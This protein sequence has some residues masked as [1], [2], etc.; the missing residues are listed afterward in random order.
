MARIDLARRAEI[1]R[2]SVQTRSRTCAAQV[3]RCSQGAV[4]AAGRNCALRCQ[5]PRAAGQRA[6]AALENSRCVSTA[7]MAHA[8]VDGLG[9]ERIP[10]GLLRDD[11]ADD[12]AAVE[13]QLGLGSGNGPHLGILGEHLMNSRC[14]AGA[15]GPD[16]ASSRLGPQTLLLVSGLD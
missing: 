1:G 8:I 9:Q 12:V 16:H 15:R 10:V 7:S 13:P 6:V 11:F 14:T 4:A 5:G 2:E 3:S